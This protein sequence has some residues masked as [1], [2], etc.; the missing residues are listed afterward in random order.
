ML[1]LNIKDSNY[2]KEFASQCIDKFNELDDFSSEYAK[3]YLPELWK[4]YSKSYQG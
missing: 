2:D 1:D 4:K 3:K